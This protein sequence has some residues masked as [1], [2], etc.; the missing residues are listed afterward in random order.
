MPFEL[1]TALRYLVR[2]RSHRGFVAFFTIISVL[3]VFVGVAALIVVLSIMTGFERELKNKVIGVY[4][5]VTVTGS[6]R[7]ALAD[8]HVPAE[9]ARKIPHVLSAA[10]YVA[11]P[12]L[13]GSWDRMR[14]LHI[15][16][17]DTS[18]EQEASDLAKFVTVGSFKIADDQILMGEQGAEHMGLHLGDKIQLTTAATVRT[19]DGK[20]VVPMQ[21][22]FE[23]AGFFKTG[24]YEYDANFGIVTLKTGQHLY[25]L[26]S[27][28]HALKVKLDNVDA[29]P[30]VKIQ[31]QDALGPDY[32]VRT[33]MDQNP[34]LF[35]AV[36][37]EKRVM[38]IILSLIIVVAALNIV[39]TLVMVVL[40]KTKDIGILRALGAT[41]VS[42]GAIF[43]LQGFLIAFVGTVTGIVCGVLIAH[44]VN[45]ISKFIE[46]H[47]G[48]TF[49]PPDVYY[50]DAIPSE[51]VPADVAWIAAC[52]LILCVGASLFPSWLAAR[53]DPVQALR[54]E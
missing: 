54:Y 46:H 7:D 9:A 43:T 52:A 28:V 6:G 22:T 16:A 42:I 34:A 15:I 26:G 5:H 53:Q 3:C 32:E 45:A 21:K 11:G 30:T 40:E 20:Q 1:A 29:A 2:S 18:L 38:F 4:A 41:R 37:M 50:L 8:W 31:L 33:W 19:P 27:R 36:Q 17:T 48:F 44:N 25:S 12:L 14:P 24:N 10:P 23:I 49:F 51:I 13:L 47:T 35:S 39:S